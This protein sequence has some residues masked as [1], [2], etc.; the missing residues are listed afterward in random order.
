MDFFPALRGLVVAALVV[1]SALITAT[2]CLTLFAVWLFSESCGVKCAVGEAVHAPITAPVSPHDRIT[3]AG[4][5]AR[6]LFL[7]LGGGA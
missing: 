1:V 7:Q 4:L 5:P 2:V 3:G 6:A